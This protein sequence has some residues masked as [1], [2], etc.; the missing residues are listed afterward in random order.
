MA[1]WHPIKRRELV[2]KLRVL[3]FTGP[4]RGTR[5]EFLGLF[6]ICGAPPARPFV[7]P[8]PLCRHVR[9]VKTRTIERFL[10]SPALAQNLQPGQSILIT[11]SGEPDLIATKTPSARG[12][13]PPSSA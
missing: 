9:S 4:Y 6:L 10:H 8:H 12:N 7:D 1:G 11:A 3:G 2:R 13:P 5:H